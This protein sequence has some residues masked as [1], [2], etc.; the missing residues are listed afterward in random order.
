MSL[1]NHRRFL[2]YYGSTS[3]DRSATSDT[4]VAWDHEHLLLE[5]RGPSFEGSGGS[6]S[7]GKQPPNLRHNKCIPNRPVDIRVPLSGGRWS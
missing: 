2:L 7:G 5:T 6:S 1:V 3:T 4:K